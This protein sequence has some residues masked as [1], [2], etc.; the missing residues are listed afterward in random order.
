MTTTITTQGIENYDIELE[1]ERDST[2]SIQSSNISLMD[3]STHSIICS[4]NE[5]S[6]IA[7]TYWGS[8]EYHRGILKSELAL[9]EQQD[10]E[11]NSGLQ[12]NVTNI[13]N[14]TSSLHNITKP[15]S[16]SLLNDNLTKSQ[17]T[18]TLKW[19][20]GDQILIPLELWQESNTI[21]KELSRSEENKIQSDI[22]LWASIIKRTPKQVTFY[23]PSLEE[24]YKRGLSF[25]E[26]NIFLLNLFFFS[27]SHK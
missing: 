11:I 9:N 20:V 27:F 12:T 5:I 4:S 16:F 22:Y 19:L 2:S 10:K 23:V 13:K 24:S 14:S 1:V 15:V 25:M 18:K 3:S 17:K 26:V 21:L 6:F 7:D 8:D